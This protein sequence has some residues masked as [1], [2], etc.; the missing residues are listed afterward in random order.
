MEALGLGEDDVTQVEF[1]GP[2]Q[3]YASFERWV[4]ERA[5]ALEAPDWDDPASVAAIAYARVMRRGRV[6]Y[7]D[8]EEERNVAAFRHLLPAALARRGLVLERVPGG[9]KVCGTI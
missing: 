8:S 2:E 9:W 5:P 7:D 3:V 6:I 4:P 1:G